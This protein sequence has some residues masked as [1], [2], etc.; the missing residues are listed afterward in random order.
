MD[1]TT[2]T[3]QAGRES[4]LVEI[5]SLTGSNGGDQYANGMVSLTNGSGIHKAD[6]DDPSTWTFSNANYQD[7]WMASYLKAAGTVTPGLNRKVA[8]ACL[9]FGSKTPLGM[10]YLFNTNYSS[11]VSGTDQFN[12]YHSDS[13]AVALPAQPLRN[14]YSTTGLSP[15]GD[16]NFAGGGWTKFN[17]PG[18]LSAAK[19]A[20]TAINLPG[21]S[22]RYLAIEILS[23]QGDTTGGGRVGFDEIAVTAAPQDSDGDGLPDDYE[24]ANT[25]PPSATTLDPAID[26]EPD[27]LTTWQEYVIGTNPNDP[28]SDDDNLNDGPEMLGAGSRPPTNPLLADT[29]GDAL[30]DFVETNTGVWVGLADTGTNP[31]DADTDSDGLKDSVETNTGTYLS[32]TNTGTNPHHANS[33]GDNAGDWYEVAIIDKNPALGSPPNSPNDSALKPNIPY[34][35]PD[36]ESSDT[37][38]THKP[39]KVYIMSGQ[40]NMVGFGQI[41]GTGPGT[42][43]TMTGAENKFPNL[44]ASGGGWTTRNDVKYRGVVSDIGNG[45]LRP[46]V[47]GG[48]FGPELGFGCVMGWHHDEPVL[49][50]KASIGN[51]SLMWDFAAP[52]TPSF[53]HTDNHT[54]AG[55]GQSPNRWLT[56]TGA[57][58][59]YVWYAG[60]QFDDC[61]KNEVDMPFPGWSAGVAYQANG[62]IGSQVRHNGVNYQCKLSHTSE[63]ASEPGV[64]SGWTTYWLVFSVT[65]TADVLDHFAADYPQW[66]AQGFEIAGYAWWQGHNDQG[67]PSA[68]QYRTNM[69]RFIQQIRAYYE[70]R[71]N[72][73]P[74]GKVLFVFR[75][76][77]EASTDAN[78]SIAVQYGNTLGGW[79]EAV[80]QG[81]GGNQITITEVPDGYG[82]GI[83]QVTVALPANLAGGGRLFA[84]MSVVV[85]TP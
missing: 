50:I 1:D 16:Y 8:W 37:G 24:L 4:A 67:E 46:D 66:A 19:A 78:T 23:G 7:E 5:A 47:A 73:D 49:L 82:P 68:S 41:A 64:G 75:R 12:L 83:D 85:T 54:Y 56:A 15:Q 39:V 84:R 55:Y 20:T 79:S 40:S 14:T 77:E 9:D 53:P 70:N 30:G 33:D 65:N 2:I 72:N 45:A 51:R 76:S 18:P 3:V 22:A 43:Q 36:P 17:T 13:P 28:D 52:T 69:A 60:K 21:V 58:S 35:L 38:V 34:P 63:A 44:V 11:G 6:P 71:Y 42:L 62:N 61:F 48:D 26:I 57:P 29:D 74:D 31:A 80:H 27:G 32:D 10:L 59:P 25:T 81:S